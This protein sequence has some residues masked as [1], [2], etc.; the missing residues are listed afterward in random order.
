MFL[1]DL[2]MEIDGSIK[3]K[4]NDRINL[5][6]IIMILSVLNYIFLNLILTFSS[7]LKNHNEY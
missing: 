7:I 5:L 4:K 3:I 6:R 2:P 1:I